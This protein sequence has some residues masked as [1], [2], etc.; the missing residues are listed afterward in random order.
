M[1]LRINSCVTFVFTSFTIL[2]SL[3]DKEYRF[4]TFMRTFL[5]HIVRLLPEKTGF[6]SQ[7]T[8]VLAVT[9]RDSKTVTVMCHCRSQDAFSAFFVTD[10]S[11][12]VN[13]KISV[14]CLP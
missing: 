14:W 9:C 3:P 10:A 13:C 8:F 6:L 7:V 12:P 5:T 11:R 4:I 1:S 2:P